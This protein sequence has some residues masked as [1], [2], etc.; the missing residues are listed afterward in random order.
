MNYCEIKLTCPSLAA[1]SCSKLE[2][3]IASITSVYI[4]YMTKITRLAQTLY[5]H[6][7][8]KW[9]QVPKFCNCTKT[10][11]LLQFE[12]QCTTNIDLVGALRFPYTQRTNYFFY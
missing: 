7:S 2:R 3:E 6:A 9:I 8:Q 1:N 5:L 10:I 11:D 4:I 12:I